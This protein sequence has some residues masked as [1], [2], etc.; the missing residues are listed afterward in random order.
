MKDSSSQVPLP[1][2]VTVNVYVVGVTTFTFAGPLIVIVFPTIGP[3]V[4]PSGRP[5]P[6]AF[7]ALP[8]KSN[9]IGVILSPS[10]IV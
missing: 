10:Q 6:D 2:A 1:V 4:T 9:V 8:P 3:R 7:V 5:I